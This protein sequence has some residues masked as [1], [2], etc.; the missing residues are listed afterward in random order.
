MNLDQ[1][2]ARACADV[3]VFDAHSVHDMPPIAVITSTAAATALRTSTPPV[4]IHVSDGLATMLD[5]TAD[6]IA[7]EDILVPFDGFGVRVGDD[8][9]LV[10]H[11][12]TN[13]GLLMISWLEPTGSRGPLL[14]QAAG[15]FGGTRPVTAQGVAV[16]GGG[17]GGE[18]GHARRFSQLTRI[19]VGLCNYMATEV[20]DVSTWDGK[21]VKRSNDAIILPPIRGAHRV[22]AV[23]Q[24][25][26]M[27]QRTLH[28]GKRLAIP[29]VRANTLVRG[30][31][32]LQACGPRHS[33]RKMIWVRP[34]VRNRD[35]SLPTFG[36]DVR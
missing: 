27:R 7:A 15:M 31:F 12:Y 5:A 24:K 9:V 26:H 29:K 22:G 23:A 10:A 18:D 21:P 2:F 16:I 30:H 6:T 20:P 3:G 17:A 35:D 19:V 36:R 8:F 25:K 14:V 1:R 32:R 11:G 13:Q 34:H 33:R 4:L 28:A